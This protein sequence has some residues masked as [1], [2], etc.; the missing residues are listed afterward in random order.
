MFWPGYF[1]VHYAFIKHRLIQC[2]YIVH[3]TWR[4]FK[5]SPQFFATIYHTDVINDI[6]DIIDI[7]DSV[8]SFRHFHNISFNLSVVLRV[9]LSVVI[10]VGKK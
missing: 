1:L 2:A 3:I 10:N 7:F 4:A 5:N 8:S 9:H 6:P